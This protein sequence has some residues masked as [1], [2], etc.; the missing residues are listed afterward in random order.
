MASEKIVAVVFDTTSVNTGDNSGV[1]KRLEQSVR[2]A[3]LELACRH[4][5]YELS[6]GASSE[7]VLGKTVQVIILTKSDFLNSNKIKVILWLYSISSLL[8]ATCMR[9]H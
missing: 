3:L 1:K 4:H 8:T 6:C 2:H 7:I 5:V 9:E